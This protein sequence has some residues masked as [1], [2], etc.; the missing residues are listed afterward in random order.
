V[1]VGG[2]LGDVPVHPVGAPE[3]TELLDEAVKVVREKTSS[4]RLPDLRLLHYRVANKSGL[5]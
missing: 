5:F 3:K 2:L 4:S 1:F